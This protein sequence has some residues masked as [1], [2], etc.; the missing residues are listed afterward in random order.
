MQA[1]KIGGLYRLDLQLPGNGANQCLTAMEIHRRMGHIS[2]KSLRYLLDHGMILGIE[3]SSIGDKITFHWSSS[4]LIHARHNC[5]IQ[6]Q[7]VPE[8]N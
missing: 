6:M 5:I 7:C 8:L 3:M 4:A 1:P 2:H